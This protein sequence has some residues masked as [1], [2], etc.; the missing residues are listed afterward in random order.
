MP[1][2]ELRYLTVNMA[3][4]FV[5]GEQLVRL[6]PREGHV[7]N[8][9]LFPTREWAVKAAQACGLAVKADGTVIINPNAA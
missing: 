8:R 2:L 3:W 4:A 6:Q 5:F 7:D 9:L 1:N